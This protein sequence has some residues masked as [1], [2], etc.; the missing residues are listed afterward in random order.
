[1]TLHR[2]SSRPGAPAARPTWLAL[3]AWTA[4]A[5]LPGLVAAAPAVDT[6]QW[7]C[8][9]CPFDKDE[10]ATAATLEA[11]VGAVSGQ[12]GVFTNSS[13]IDR[14]GG[15]LVLGGAVDWR[16]TDGAYGSLVASDLGLDTRQIAGEYG[17]EGRLRVRLGYVELPRVLSDGARTP[18]LGVG[19]G[20]LT[21]PGG[22]PAATTGA[23][24]L[25]A[26]LQDV[27]IGF[28]RKRLDLGADI[29]LGTGWSTRV[30]LR[31]D[32]RDGTQ[33]LAGSFFANAAQLVAPVD[34]VTDQLEVTAAYAGARWQASLG[35]LA[36]L[37]RNGEESLT[38]TNPFGS[39][40]LVG[41]HGQLAL[42][43]DNQFHQLRGALGWQISPIVRASADIAVGR[44]TQD[45]TY[46][47]AT[48]NPDLAV[49]G[50]P[51]STLDGR[52]NT[53]NASL[54][55]SA[56]P[57]PALRL[58]AS[59]TRDER[60]NRS[61]VS[62]YPSVSTDL[63]I[64]LPRSNPRYSFT[65]DRVRLSADWRGPGTLRLAGGADHDTVDRTQQEA[66][67][68]RE[69]TVWARASLQPWPML[70]ASVKLQ[71][72]E[73]TLSDYTAVAAID[74]A[75]NPLL[76][77]Y[78]LAERRRNA[79]GVRAD[80]QLAE[81]V[82]LG[83]TLDAREDTYGASVLGLIDGRSLDGSAELSWAL[84]D[85]TQLRGYVQHERVR[86]RQNGSQLYAV[87]DWFARHNDAV[88]LLGGGVKHL[89]LKGKL[90]LRAD[91]TVARSRSHVTVD[92]GTAGAGFPVARTWQDT[93]KLQANYELSRQ[94]TLIGG[95]WFERYDSTDW[96]LDGLLP[97]GVP[98]LLALGETAP[99]YRVHVLRVAMRHRF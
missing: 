79:A 5:A 19:S 64:G 82:A 95:W 68:T 49:A 46:L 75:Q 23:M 28:K 52:A 26:T 37:F 98:N 3:A 12:P 83:M 55:L 1:M 42:A 30:T 88:D 51:S 9:T 80:V 81:G 18:F 94:T 31:H 71:H 61:P 16:G 73:R 39:G 91:L 50:L 69:G 78:S 63:F 93:F 62:L 8:E 90:E 85:E 72:A 74:P 40:L 86:S 66:A 41:G 34:Q 60:E 4:L 67:T 7:K 21:L 43:P 76:R 24:P 87:A 47:A 57:M 27:D 59:V 17:R 44:M 99:S 77:K 25:G 53:L 96:H 14:Q 84:S 33:R 92:N 38:W 20:V 89:A 48:L 15:F 2:I 58:A 70:S 54:R 29:A 22:Y 36:S 35:Y 13:G 11:G 6:S 10:P 45:A 56:T 65:R 32:V 97:N